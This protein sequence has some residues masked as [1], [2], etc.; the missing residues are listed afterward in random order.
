ME[1]LPYIAIDQAAVARLFR[2]WEPGR[3]AEE[4]ALLPKGRRNTNY[5]VTSGRDRYLLRLYAAVDDGWQKERPLYAH[6]RNLLPLPKLLHAEFDRALF[7]TPFAIFEFVEGETLDNLR[8]HGDALPPALFEEIGGCL[9]RLHERKYSKVG[10]LDR[11][12]EVAE[13]LPPLASWYNLFMAR[14]A[15]RLGSEGVDR[16][17]AYVAERAPMLREIERAVTLVHGDFR[18]ENLLVRD[19]K[20]AA[21]L[22]WEFAMAGHSCSD[23]GQFVRDAELI[24]GAPE[25]HFVEGHQRAAGRA[26]PANWKQLGR[27]LDLV[28][29]LQMLDGHDERPHQY[30]GLKHLIMRTLN[31]R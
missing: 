11:N 26:L 9:A 4:F 16:V 21:I 13:E 30:A 17:R 19:G 1:R 2:R 15:Q 6:L 14:A 31:D 27:L 8:A 28:N 24:S 22:D 3:T 29:L 12:L 7:P 10:F 23:L 18:P 20:L 25:S 5:R